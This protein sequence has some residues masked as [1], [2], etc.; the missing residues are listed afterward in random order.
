MKFEE[1]VV[2][3]A[4]GRMVRRDGWP[5]YC[6]YPEAFTHLSTDSI[7]ADD[8]EVK[9][10]PKPKM[11]AYWNPYIAY[12]TLNGPALGGKALVWLLPND[13]APDG[14]ERAP[15]HDEK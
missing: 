6:A 3:A 14:W 9:P 12:L 2:M 10:D 4:T 1:A 7:V 11:I 15:E 5:E 8:W 13:Q